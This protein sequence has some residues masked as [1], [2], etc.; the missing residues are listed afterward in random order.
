MHYASICLDCEVKYPE[1]VVDCPSCG[2]QMVVF[3]AGLPDPDP[4]ELA[5]PIVIGDRLDG[6]FDSASGQNFTS[7]SARKRFYRDNQL[8]RIS[9]GDAKREGYGQLNYKYMHRSITYGGQRDRRSG[10]EKSN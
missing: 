4:D 9:V 3:R 2:G 5:C 1:A 6:T 10:A 7:R 8:R